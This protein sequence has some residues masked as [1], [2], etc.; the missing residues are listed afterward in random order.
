MPLSYIFSIAA[1]IISAKHMHKKQYTYFFHY[2]FCA[3]GILVGKTIE[4]YAKTETAVLIAGRF[5]YAFIAFIGVFWLLFICQ[6]THQNSKILTK[7]SIFLLCIIPVLTIILQSTNSI[8]HLVWKEHS[9][10]QNGSYLINVITEYG[11]W[12]YVHSIY[13]YGLFAL[14]CIIICIE[15]SGLWKIFKV[16][17]TLIIASIACPV[18]IS[19][20]YVLRDKDKVFWD[21]ST[22]AYAVS[23]FLNTIIFTK[24]NF[25]DLPQP[26]RK[27]MLKTVN[28]GI[29]T[30]TPD[31]IIIDA[32]P[33]AVNHFGIKQL[34]GKNITTILKNEDNTFIKTEDLQ[35]NVKGKKCICSSKILN[36]EITAHIDDGITVAYILITK[37]IQPAENHNTAYTAEQLYNSIY[38]TAL[39][40]N[41]SKRELEVLKEL[42][43]N[44][45]NK[46]IAENLNISIDTVHTHVSRILKKLNCKNRIALF[47]LAASFLG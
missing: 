26:S 27:R 3:D 34:I 16:R 39:Q 8:H 35:N 25:F 4:F 29:T 37:I 21:F 2:L 41:I 47:E 13:S 19:L 36:L 6:W 10:K 40:S 46:Q 33:E 20:I 5:T 14:S 43:S 22:S 32:T 44:S 17:S 28:L 23:S 12:F 30:V 7:K 42:L 45:T 9:L 31:G 18:L 24:Y 15:N 38:Q 11:I 1:L